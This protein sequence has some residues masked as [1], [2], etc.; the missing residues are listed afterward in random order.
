[1]VLFEL[2]RV[3]MHKLM[4]YLSTHPRTPLIFQKIISSE[5]RKIRVHWSENQSEDFTFQNR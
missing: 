4:C 3:L 5:E 2:G 1:M